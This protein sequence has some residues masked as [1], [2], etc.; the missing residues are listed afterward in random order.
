MAKYK[1][2]FE[3]RGSV[4]NM[5]F[6]KRKGK[7]CVRKKTGVSREVF[8]T[9]P[10][11][12]NSRKRA[13]EFGRSSSAASLLRQAL[14][15]AIQGIKYENLQGRLISKLSKVL[16]SEKA[17]D[18]GVS[19]FNNEDISLL[20]GFSFNS[21][22]DSIFR[23]D[24]RVTADRDKSVMRFK[25]DSF[26]PAVK[27]RFPKGATHMQLLFSGTGIDFEGK[28]FITEVE[29]SGYI[30][31]GNSRQEGPELTVRMTADREWLWFGALTVRFFQEVNGELYAI[32]NED[33]Q[34]VQIVFAEEGES[35]EWVVEPVRHTAAVTSPKDDI[36][37]QN[38]VFSGS[39][40][41]TGGLLSDIQYFRI[42][43][44]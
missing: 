38:T 41:S 16:R 43:C 35:G 25:A 7:P 2:I 10:A 4:G 31:L 5:T 11:F 22:T 3:F 23:A 39:G 34:T 24:Y 13:T 8:W 42:Q 44:W 1:G 30:R 9:H 29:K 14:A 26:I 18:N 27:I 40:V 17:F 15:E 36:V 6:Y 32:N 21:K 33:Y 19:S 20:R 28:E 12:A 37:Y